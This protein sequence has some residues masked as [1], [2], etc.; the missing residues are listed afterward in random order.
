MKLIIIILIKCAVFIMTM[1]R[2]VTIVI[3]VLIKVVYLL[4]GMLK[5]IL[6]VKI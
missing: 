2:M 6:D 4:A 5:Q 1:L 3:T